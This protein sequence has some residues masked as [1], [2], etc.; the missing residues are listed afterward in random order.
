MATAATRSR[1]NA[2]SSFQTFQWKGTDQQGRKA[3][4]EIR[5]KDINLARA[6]LR[7]QMI[8]PSQLKKG[9]AKK[10]LLSGAKKIKSKDIT[11]FTRQLATMMKAGVPLV[12]SFE[13]TGEGH[14]NPS[15][16]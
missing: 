8:T 2:P 13:I 14:S 6:E 16:R 11:L 5:A 15:M 3:S 9:K 1:K 7:R 12:Q 10:G 4:G